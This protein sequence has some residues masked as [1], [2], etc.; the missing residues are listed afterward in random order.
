MASKRRWA[1]MAAFFHMWFAAQ[2]VKRFVP[3]DWNCWAL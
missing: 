1:V 3:V 2:L